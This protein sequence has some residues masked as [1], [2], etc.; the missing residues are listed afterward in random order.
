MV[1][2][3]EDHHAT[4]ALK[5]VRVGAQKRSRTFSK[6]GHWQ[7]AIRTGWV[8]FHV[9]AHAPELGVLRAVK[10]RRRLEGTFSST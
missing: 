10:E 5:Y 8:Y 9:N 3:H 4:S 6:E 2:G 7:S 1:F